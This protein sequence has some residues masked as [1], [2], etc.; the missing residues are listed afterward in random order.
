[1]NAIALTTEWSADDPTTDFSKPKI[2]VVVRSKHNYRLA[3]TC[4]D[5]AT[6]SETIKPYDLYSLRSHSEFQAVLQTLATT[7]TS[8]PL[9]PEVWALDALLIDNSFLKEDSVEHL[10]HLHKQQLLPPFMI[11][12]GKGL[13][14]ELGQHLSDASQTILQKLQP[15]LLSWADLDGHNDTLQPVLTTLQ[16]FYQTARLHFN[17]RCLQSLSAQGLSQTQ[18]YYRT[19]VSERGT[20]TNEW[21]SP[22][23]TAVTGFTLQEVTDAGGWAKLVLTSDLP[24]I[25]QHLQRLLDNQLSRTDYRVKAKDGQILHLITEATPQWD[26]TTQRVVEIT[27]T[28]RRID[29]DEAATD[30]A[31]VTDT[32]TALDADTSFFD[33]KPSLPREEHLDA[34]INTAFELRSRD[35]ILSA[36]SEVTFELFS[37]SQWQQVLPSLLSKLGQAINA[38]ASFLYE[39]QTRRG[40]LELRQRA[41][42]PVPATSEERDSNRQI[43]SISLQQSGLMEVQEVLASGQVAM[44][45]RTELNRSAQAFLTTLNVRSLLLMP[46]FVDGDWWGTL[47]FSSNTA[48]DWGH[49]EQQALAIA[50]NTI[51]TAIERSADDYALQTII[52]GT[53]RTAGRDFF[54]SVVRYLT[55]VFEADCCFV[56]ERCSDQR[57]FTHAVWE[58][59]QFAER[60]QYDLSDTPCQLLDDQLIVDIPDD[61]QQMY[62]GWLYLKT[63]DVEAVI[64]MA[65]LDNHGSVLGHLVV[66]G[67]QNLNRSSRAVDIMRVFAMRAGMEME[68]FNIEQENQHLAQI[69]LESPNLIMTADSEGHVTFE[70]PTAKRLKQQLGL[71]SHRDLLPPDHEQLVQLALDSKQYTQSAELQ[72]GQST[73]EWNYHYQPDL[74]QVYLYA[75]DLTQRKLIEHQLRKDAFHDPLTGLPNRGYFNTLLEKAIEGMERRPGNLFAILFL[76]LDRF[77]VI[78]DSLGH[79]CG[80]QL[81]KTVASLL[82]ECL[83]PDDDIARFGG[84]E[85]AILLNDIEYEHEVRDIADR[86]QNALTQPIRLE[87]HETFTS[88]SIGI[89]F[90]H[91]R[92]HTG[93][94]MLRDADIA[95]YSAKQNGKARYAI[96]DQH[97]HDEAMHTLQLETDLR[98]AIRKEQLVVYYQPIY[99]VKENRVWGFEALVRWQHPQRG[100]LDPQEFLSI[101]EE[102]GLIRE[103][104][105]W[106]LRTALRQLA[107]WRRYHGHA[108]LNMSINFSAIHFNHMGMLANIGNILQEVSL[109]PSCLDIE[110]TESVIME[111]TNLSNEIF[112][113]L[114]KRGTNISIDDFGVG[115]SSLSRLINLPIDTLKVDRSFIED[116]LNNA[117][118][119]NVTIAVIDLA[120]D[121]KKKVIAEG[122]EDIGQY[123]VLAHLGC[124]FVQGYLISKPLTC[125]QATEFLQQPPDLSINKISIQD[126]L[127]VG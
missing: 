72:L 78:N 56:A 114:G 42:W 38:S 88:A 45:D 67:K 33:A 58:H 117:N 31:Q 96:F 91:H 2:A 95:M 69:A 7:Q 10:Q 34:I 97:M 82:K 12:T 70:N 116:M 68:R 23:F 6:H 36:V 28:V 108:D 57:F 37:T 112:E 63:H 55:R 60:F 121:L 30:T 83:R 32:L 113:V 19:H 50:S 26:E 16:L 106:V 22:S 110:V 93:E 74:N 62:P 49:G 84:D 87:N 75:I 104:D 53:A 52:E 80:D 105:E 25:E 29:Q 81:L 13:L 85:F 48:H 120:H 79:V 64:A 11:V 8:S 99:S 115:Y 90:S 77:K 39:N 3:V 103:I 86:I 109:P 92:Y 65:I 89:A 102:M 111:A 14:S 5:I 122:V 54:R 118:S 100:L 24:K 51:G 4:L 1:M 119:M 61:A 125:D 126:L 20:L 59:F 44:I 41:V 94:D 76:D 43:R 101:A 124:E 71:D 73:F 127:P 107:R 17:N 35:L 40:E 15:G 98:N 46:V 9:P 47:G 18:Y 66:M 27:G 21:L 123:Q